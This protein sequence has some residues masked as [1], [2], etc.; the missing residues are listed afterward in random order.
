VIEINKADD[1]QGGGKD[2]EKEVLRTQA[3]SEEEG[4]AQQSCQEFD[5]RITYGYG[6]ATGPA[7]AQENDVTDERNVVIEFDPCTAMGTSGRG[8]D[9][10]FSFRDS[11]DTNVEK[12]SHYKAKQK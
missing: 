9:D 7:F 12:A 3:V 2:E 6:M 8:I 4:R 10:G 5:N 1:D 11:M